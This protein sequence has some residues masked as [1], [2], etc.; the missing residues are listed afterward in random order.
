MISSPCRISAQTTSLPE[1]ALSGGLCFPEVLSDYSKYW[2][3]GYNVGLG[4]G[5]SQQ[6]SASSGIKGTGTLSI[7]GRYGRC[8]PDN[9]RVIDEAGIPGGIAVIKS[10]PLSVLQIEGAVKFYFD[11]GSFT[12]PFI[13]VGIGYYH[14][15]G[16][17]I[18][19]EENT[20]SIYIQHRIWSD[21]TDVFCTSLDAGLDFPVMNNLS[22]F[23]GAEFGGGIKLDPFKIL[24][25]A[26]IS[27]GTRITFPSL[28]ITH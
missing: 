3:P 11:I 25:S 14:L 21:P 26:W 1:L 23:I 17:Q 16:S 6:T 12:Q 24:G 18:F 2:K 9:A 28:A 15:S 7:I 5:V 27:G 4:I 13:G 19:F 10:E 22:F 8:E 20:E